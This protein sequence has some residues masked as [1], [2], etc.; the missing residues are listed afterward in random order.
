MCDTV[1][2]G[3]VQNVAYIDTDRLFLHIDD[4]ERA[5]RLRLSFVVILL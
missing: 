4:M 1:A 3:C 2:G 5:G